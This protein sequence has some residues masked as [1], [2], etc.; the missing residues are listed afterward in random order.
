MTHHVAGSVFVARLES[1][2]VV[3]GFRRFRI[4][5]NPSGPTAYVHSAV[6]SRINAA[7]ISVH[8][9]LGPGFLEAIYEEALCVEFDKQQVNR[10]LCLRGGTH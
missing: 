3:S 10:Q 6:T 4:S 8:K 2:P 9:S 7:A 1:P 5:F